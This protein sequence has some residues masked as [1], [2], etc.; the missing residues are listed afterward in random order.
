LKKFLCR[1]GNPTRQLREQPTRAMSALR[2]KADIIQYA[3]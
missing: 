2:G 1:T 3:A